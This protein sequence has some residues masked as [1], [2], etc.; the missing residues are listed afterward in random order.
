[1]GTGRGGRPTARL[2]LGRHAQVAQGVALRQAGPA[3]LWRGRHQLQAWTA[4]SL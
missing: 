4:H 1:M 3:H 2:P